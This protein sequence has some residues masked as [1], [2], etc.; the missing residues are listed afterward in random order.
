[1][2]A[3]LRSKPQATIIPQKAPY[4]VTGR[5]GPPGSSP[6]PGPGSPSGSRSGTSSESESGSLLRPGSSPELKS[7]PGSPLRSPSRSGWGSAPGTGHGLTRGVGPVE[8]P[9]SLGERE[10]TDGQRG[11]A[12]VGRPVAVVAREGVVVTTPSPGPHPRSIPCRSGLP[13]RFEPKSS[14][15]PGT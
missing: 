4:V 9:L 5:R 1:M 3:T 10:R 7:K 13:L 15:S 8:P 12:A 11:R 14:R 2:Y 6:R